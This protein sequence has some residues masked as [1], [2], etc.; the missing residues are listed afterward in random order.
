MADP[1]LIIAAAGR[2]HPTE[3]VSGDAWAV[4]WHAEQCRIA[5]ID[6]LGHGPEAA[7]VAE[8]ATTALARYPDL[9]PLSALARCDEALAGT[10]GAAVSVAAIDCRTSRLVYAGIGNIEAQLWQAGASQRLIAYRGIVGVT[11]RTVRA[12]SFDLRP[13]W[14]LLLYTDGISSH[15]NAAELDSTVRADPRAAADAAL[16]RWGRS[17]DDATAVVVCPSHHAR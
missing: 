6:G 4:H 2:P 14:W 9:D 5:V 15:L 13:D 8:R 17:T 11:R 1:P 16:A 12:F 10:R 3:Q 7:T